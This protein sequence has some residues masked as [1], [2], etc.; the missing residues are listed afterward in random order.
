MKHQS[1]KV[2][3]TGMSRKLSDLTIHGITKHATSR[4]TRKVKPNCIHNWK[5]TTHCV[6][7]AIN[8]RAVFQSFGTDLSDPTEERQWRKLV[9]RAINVR[10]RNPKLDDWTCR[11][12]S[13]EEESMLHL[14][15]CQKT[16]QLW[17]AVLIF[18]RDVLK[19]PD[20]TTSIERAIIF[21]Q[22]NPRDMLPAAACA[23]IRHAFNCFYHDFANVDKG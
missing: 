5:H 9:H 12:C 23:F 7:F 14:I 11:L 13:C 10:N 3:A 21:N 20:M 19:A 2:K 22:A 4:L 1:T 6:R 18:C 15:Q 17:A 16:K 8:F